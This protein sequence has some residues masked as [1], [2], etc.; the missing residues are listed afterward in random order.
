MATREGIEGTLDELNRAENSAELSPEQK[1]A[2]TDRLCHPD[3]EGWANGEARGT[4][5]GT[6]G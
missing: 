1:A 2:A 4:R 5:Q 6:R 3:V